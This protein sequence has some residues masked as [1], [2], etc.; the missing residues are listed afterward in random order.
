MYRNLL[1]ILAVFGLAILLVGLTFS[2]TQETRADYVFVNGTEP[3]TLDPQ[4]MTGQPE[5]RIG[6]AVFEGLTF[7]DNETLKPVPGSAVSWETTPDGKRWTFR[8]R[9]GIRWS[10]GDPVTAHDFVYAWK[11]LQEPSVASEY[12]YL[13]HFVRHAEA[14]NSYA[15][16]VKSLRGDPEAEKEAAR[17]GLVRGL[18]AL[19]AANPKGIAVADFSAFADARHLRD[20]VVGTKDPGILGALAKENGTFTAAEAEALAVALEAEATRREQAHAAAVAHFGVDEG[21]FA[22]EPDVF[23]VEL[24]QFVPYFL[25]LTAFYPTFP[26][27]RPTV[28]RWPNDWFLPGRIVS[29][30]PFLLESWRVNSKIRLRKNPD[31]WAA[32]QVSLETVEALSLENRTTAFNLYVSGEVDWG[33]TGY[34]PDLIDV[35]RKR[36]DYYSG[37]G[38]IVYFY[39]FNCTKKPLDDARV[40]RAL[41]LAF[42]RTTLV[43]KVTRAGQVPATTVVAPGIPGYRS[44]ESRMGHDPAAARRL[45]AEAGFPEGRGFPRLAILHNT[46]E[47]HKKVA[48]YIANQFRETLGIEVNAVNQEWQSYQ[49]SVR[50]FNYDIARAGWIGDYRDPN[51]FLDMWITKGGNNQTGWGDP[52]YDRLIQLAADPLGVPSLPAADRE[53]LFA[54]FKEKDEASRLLAQVE[55]AGATEERIQ[56]ALAL[57]LHLFREAEAILVQEA[58]PILPIYF[59]VVTGVVSPRVE[60][61][62]TKV[63]DDDGSMIPNLQ[64]LHP[65]RD[66][67]MRPAGPEKP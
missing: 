15:G 54:R 31:Y 17:E 16:H 50:R 19:A 56:R 36:P 9:P 44:P 11:R 48:E 43:E 21:V 63:R 46:D 64:D 38:M 35:V 52:F 1:G 67:R 3:K 59:Y 23:V 34:P 37:P 33:P 5:G 41:S 60:G 40:R 29:N 39:R 49:E 42:D 66:V 28:T 24:N 10:N 30:G 55:A 2:S 18:R 20:A 7:R 45:L 22:P 25:E 4:K 58:F 12:A 51:T 26:V 61:F 62:H 14:Y 27:H 53:A 8:M 47:G 13:L 32:D 6:D 57:R 65:F